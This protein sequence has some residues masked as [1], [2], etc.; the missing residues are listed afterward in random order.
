MGASS[1]PHLDGTLVPVEEPS[2]ASTKD[3]CSAARGPLFD[4]FIGSAEHGQRKSQAQRL[5]G[6]QVDDE[7]DLGRLLD[8]QRAGRLPLEDA[9]DIAALEPVSLGQIGTIAYVKPSATYQTC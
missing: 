5:C 9:S 3:L 8:R 2:T 6:L 1:G 7:L 4:D